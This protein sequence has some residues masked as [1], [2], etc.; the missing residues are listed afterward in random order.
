MMSKKKGFI[1]IETLVVVAVLTASLLLTYSTYNS[2][3]VKENIRIKYNDSTHLYRAFHLSQFFRN[4]RFDYLVS[5][6][7]K[8]PDPQKMNY[9]TPFSCEN[10]GFFEKGNINIALCQTLYN[11]LHISNMYL[12]YKDLTEFQDC[13]DYVGNACKSL[14][15]QVRAEGVN[16][17]KTIGGNDK[18]GY[19]LIIEFEECKDGTHG[20]YN[21][22]DSNYVY[23]YTTIELGDI[24]S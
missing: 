13:N 19:R 6:L 24:Y 15:G 14:Y 5:N 20:D 17:I 4:F 9:I 11:Q 18:D 8:D 7:S 21:T 16:F 3:V 10:E 1:F 2:A 12:T 23:Y 22:C